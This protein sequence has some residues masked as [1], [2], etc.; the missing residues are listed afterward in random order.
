MARWIQACFLFPFFRNHSTLESRKE[1][2]WQYPRKYRETV[3]HY[4]RLRYR[5]LPYLY[6]LFVAQEES[7]DP[8]VRPVLYDFESPE[9][10]ECNDQFMVGPEMMHAPLLS[11][12]KN[13][14]LVAIPDG[15]G[16][17]DLSTGKR[18]DASEKRAVNLNESPLFMRPGAVVPVQRE[19]RGNSE[20]DLMN[21][22]FLLNPGPD[23]S[24]SETTF[25]ADDGLTFDYRSGARSQIGVRVTWG[26]TVE[27]VTR[28]DSEAVGRIRP[29]FLLTQ[30]PKAVTLNG[31]LCKASAFTDTFTGSPIGLYLLD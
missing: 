19:V 18:V 22:V 12:K 17:F 3:A 16:W 1:E 21:P 31:S 5:F 25:V 6:Q 24:V 20:V 30:K 27:I 9:W 26:E 8:I 14:R 13:E 23:G 10:Y 4:I 11:V 2:P 29:S 28:H 15:P 7:G